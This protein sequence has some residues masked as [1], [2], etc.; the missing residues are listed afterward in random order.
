MQSNPCNPHIS[1]PYNNIL[2]TRE[3][4]KDNLVFISKC[5]HLN[6]AKRQLVA[7]NAWS[8]KSFTIVLARALLLM[9]LTTFLSSNMLHENC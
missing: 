5:F 8:D 3:S 6:N 1:D 4:N 2:E 9:I 7:L